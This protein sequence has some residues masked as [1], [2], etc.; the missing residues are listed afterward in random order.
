MWIFLQGILRGLRATAA[1]P[2]GEA[3][4]PNEGAMCTQQSDRQQH[5]LS[6]AV[7]FYTLFKKSQK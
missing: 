4:A 1:S 3:L 7:L 6:L 2:V 5:E